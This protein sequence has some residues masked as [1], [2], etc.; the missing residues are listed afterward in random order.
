MEG[1]GDEQVEEVGE[2]VGGHVVVHLE[3]GLSVLQVC[4]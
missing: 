2:G 1:V 3:R 4:V